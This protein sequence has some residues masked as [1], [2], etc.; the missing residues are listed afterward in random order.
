MAPQSH[1]RGMAFLIGA[2]WE[3][4]LSPRAVFDPRFGA[5]ISAARMRSIGWW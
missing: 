2:V 5:G 3:C 4:E 1:V